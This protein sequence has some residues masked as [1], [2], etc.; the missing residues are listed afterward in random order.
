M[1]YIGKP[2]EVVIKNCEKCGNG[3]AYKSDG[4]NQPLTCQDCY[5]VNGITYI[6]KFDIVLTNKDGMDFVIPL[7]TTHKDALETATLCNKEIDKGTKMAR[8]W[9]EAWPVPQ[10]WPHYN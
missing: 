2:N 8:G 1:H 7:G 6:M 5:E 10:G 3:F 9:R 4:K